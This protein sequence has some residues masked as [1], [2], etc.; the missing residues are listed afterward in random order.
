MRFDREGQPRKAET[1]H[2]FGGSDS[3]PVRWA[4]SPVYNEGKPVQFFLTA[5]EHVLEVLNTEDGPKADLFLLTNDRD[6]V[7]QGME[8]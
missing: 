1:E 2:I 7:P 3:K 4:W 6:Y 8:N 5:G